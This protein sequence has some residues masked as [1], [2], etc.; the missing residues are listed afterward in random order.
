MPQGS[1]NLS[2]AGMISSGMSRLSARWLLLAACTAAVLGALP[3]EIRLVP[4]GVHL[5]LTAAALGVVIQ[6]HAPQHRNL[7]R[8]FRA[9]LPAWVTLHC[10]TSVYLQFAFPDLG[11]SFDQLNLPASGMLVRS[12]LDCVIWSIL[13]LL[14]RGVVN[15]AFSRARVP[16]LLGC[17]A[18]LIWCALLGRFMGGITVGDYHLIFRDDWPLGQRSVGIFDLDTSLWLSLILPLSFLRTAPVSSLAPFAAGLSSARRLL[19]QAALVALV[20]ILG[21]AVKHSFY[22]ELPL[23]DSLSIREWSAKC[24]SIGL[25]TAVPEEA[26]Y[27]GV[28]VVCLLE[29]IP[30][31]LGPGAHLF[32]AGAGSTALFVLTHLGDSTLVLA[33]SFAF[34][35]VAAVLVLRYKSLDAAIVGHALFDVLSSVWR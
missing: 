20:V 23:I 29:I 10:A 32:L 17:V 7:S 1:N 14:L 16:R 24:G 33:F 25:W 31:T 11:I 8:V 28:V 35:V 9:L 3:S 22:S 21:M 34:G 15:A 18:V 6:P 19:I 5:I 30:A 26:L 27:R 2:S 4:V 12:V 13:A